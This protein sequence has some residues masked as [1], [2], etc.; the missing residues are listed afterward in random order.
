MA[1]SHDYTRVAAALG[2]I[3]QGADETITCLIVYEYGQ[4]YDTP[5]A[6][7]TKQLQEI[8]RR[9]THFDNNTSIEFKIRIENIN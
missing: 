8:Y 1:V 4:N 2:K 5:P 6:S 3:S 9:E 7:N